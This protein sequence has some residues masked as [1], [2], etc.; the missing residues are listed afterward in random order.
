MYDYIPR[1]VVVL[2]TSLVLRSILLVLL[3]Q[4]LSILLLVRPQPSRVRIQRRIVIR[5]PQQTLNGQQNR[6]HVIRRRPLLLQNIQANVPKL[7]DV[8]VET[9]RGKFHD[10]RFVRVLVRE[11]KRQRVL[12]V[13]VH[14]PF[15]AFD[16]PDPGEDVIPI[17][18]GGDAGIRGGHQGHQFRL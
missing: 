16:G 9:R 15:G 11:R 13:F 12:Q 1:V 17:R 2:I 3:M 18:E 4:Q 8:R 10:R 6:P 14:R 5:L 7:I